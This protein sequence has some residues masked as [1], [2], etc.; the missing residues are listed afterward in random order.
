MTND[1]RGEMERQMAGLYDIAV[2]RRVLPYTCRACGVRVVRHNPD[3]SGCGLCLACYDAA[4]LENEH[5]DG[6]HTASPVHACQDCRDIHPIML[7][8]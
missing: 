5:A 4:G 6:L 2:P 3:E 1:K 7:R 8:R